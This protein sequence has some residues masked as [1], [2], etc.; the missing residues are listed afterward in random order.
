MKLKKR[1]ITTRYLCIPILI[2]S[3]T[4]FTLVFM[5]GV[6]L[7]NNLI[8]DTSIFEKVLGNYKNL[9]RYEDKG[10]LTTNK[11]K[12]FTFETLYIKPDQLIFVFYSPQGYEAYEK[13]SYI[14]SGNKYIRIFES[15]RFPKNTKERKSIRSLLQ[16]AAGVTSTSSL[17]IPSLLVGMFNAWSRESPIGMTLE[18]NE[19][20]DPIC[21]VNF[22]RGSGA[23]ETYWVR[24]NGTIERFR[25]ELNQPRL[26]VTDIKYQLIKIQE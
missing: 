1:I 11:G 17:V 13:M 4:L 5:T 8:C 18:S 3:F 24:Q 2:K 7:A 14:M 19:K 9:T 15:D 20:G 21:K 10:I 6:S 12:F 26:L 25:R 22:E 16:S 23:K